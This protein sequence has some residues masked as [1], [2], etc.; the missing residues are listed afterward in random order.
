MTHYDISLTWIYANTL[1]SQ[2]KNDEIIVNLHL[3]AISLPNG[4]YNVF[5]NIQGVGFNGFQ[6]V[7]QTTSFCKKKTE[8]QRKHPLDPPRK[9]T[10]TNNKTEPTSCFFVF[11]LSLT[12]AIFPNMNIQ[13]SS[14][15]V[16]TPKVMKYLLRVTVFCQHQCFHILKV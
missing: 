12:N 16:Q 4:K 15:P 1:R 11:I 8:Q 9:K 10:T 2:R 7:F 13:T 3:T 5:L 6:Y 14:E